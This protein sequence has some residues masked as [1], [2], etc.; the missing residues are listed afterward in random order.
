[1]GNYHELVP[2][3]FLAYQKIEMILVTSRTTNKYNKTE[4]VGGGYSFII[5]FCLFRNNLVGVFPSIKKKK[6]K[7]LNEG[8]SQLF[9]I[10]TKV[11]CPN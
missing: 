10:S 7:D 1:M 4:K 9:V 6:K 2:L 3:A 5:V 8:W 11:L